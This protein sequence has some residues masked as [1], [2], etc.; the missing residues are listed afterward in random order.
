MTLNDIYN[1]KIMTFKMVTNDMLVY[2][3]LFNSYL[4]RLLT[5]GAIKYSTQVS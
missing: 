5:H 3:T 4:H 1:N 2:K